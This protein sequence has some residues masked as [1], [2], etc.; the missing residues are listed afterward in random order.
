MAGCDIYSTF[1]AGSQ[2]FQIGL[3][4]S[5]REATASRI[6]NGLAE[7]TRLGMGV[8]VSGAKAV[9]AVQET[10]MRELGKEVRNRTANYMDEFCNGGKAVGPKKEGSYERI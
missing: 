3:Q 10:V 7:Y 9:R 8:N 5:S 4:F 6:P 2:Y 1:D